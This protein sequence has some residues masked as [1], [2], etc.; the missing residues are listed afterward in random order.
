MASI[1]TITL[2]QETLFFCGVPDDILVNIF[3]RLYDDPRD[4]ARL[5]CVST[6]FCKVIQ[7]VCWKFRLEKTFPRL[8]EE[9]LQV[10]SPRLHSCPEPPGGWAAFQKLL[11]CCPGLWHAGVLLENW[12]FGLDRELEW[13]DN[14]GCSGVF[15]PGGVAPQVS[16]GS[17]VCDRPSKRAREKQYTSITISRKFSAVGLGVGI[18]CSEPEGTC[19]YGYGKEEDTKTGEH[20]A[21]YVSNGFNEGAQSSEA[22]M[23]IDT[24]KEGWNKGEGHED[25][26][27]MYTHFSTVEDVANELASANLMD[28]CSINKETGTQ[29]CR[30]MSNKRPRECHHEHC[31]VTTGPWNLS[32]E[33]GNKLLANRF[34]ADSLYICDWP[35]CIHPGDRR[36]Y[37]LFRGVFKNFK[38]SH[39]WRNLKDMQAKATNVGCAFCV[40]KS[41]WD[42]V[43]TF[44]LKRSIEFHD[45]GEP[46]VRAYVCENGHV[47]GAWTDRPTYAP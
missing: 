5:A 16:K 36:M 40:C 27:V 23:D 41:T 38:S 34:R 7:T 12:D 6:R 17:H 30:H 18:P 13:F 21:E 39:V 22:A 37:K 25:S 31:H 47:A 1:D 35:G 28:S 3:C 43:T 26:H 44:C 29:Q 11:V 32:R 46:V 15:F 33:Q 8:V 10:P 9:L 24:I 2:F 19:T 20:G 14:G 4:F 45:D 42:M